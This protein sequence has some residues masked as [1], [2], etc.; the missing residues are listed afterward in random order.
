MESRINIQ[1]KGQSALKPLFGIGAY[2][3]KSAVEE[4]LLELVYFRVSQINGCAYCLDMHSKDLRAKGETEQRIYGLSAW[5]ETPYYTE[6]ERAA[7]AWAEALT[8]CEVPDSVYNEVKSQFSDEDLIDLT[9]AITTINTWN[10]INLAF[11]YGVGTYQVG[12]FG[13]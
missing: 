6:R 10:R 13:G 7:L 8:K 3:K 2:L 12:Q 1:E 9:M 4:M 5:R 11:P